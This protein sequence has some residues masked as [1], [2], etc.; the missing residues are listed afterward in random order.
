[1]ICRTFA[2]IIFLMSGASLFN[3]ATA[4]PTV[5]LE[6]TSIIGEQESPRVRYTI[7]WQKTQITTLPKRPWVSLI[8]HELRP[9]DRETFQQQLQLDQLI[10]PNE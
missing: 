5:D 6:G 8:K 3:I 10:Q 9:I 7:P 1:M 2:L 4:A